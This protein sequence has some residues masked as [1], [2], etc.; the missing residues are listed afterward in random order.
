MKIIYLTWGETP[1]SHGVF[2]SQVIGQ[3]AQTKQLLPDAEFRLVSG[4]PVVH[5]G[6]VR[7]KLRYLDELK[8][9]RANLGTIPFEWIPIYVTQNLY[10]SSRRTFEWMCFGARGKL[11]RTVVEFKPDIVHCRSYHAAWAALQVRQAGAHSFKIV[12][13]ARGLFPEEVALKR[14]YAPGDADFQHL[15]QIEARLLKECDVTIAVSDTMGEHYQALGARNVEVVYLSADFEKLKVP[16]KPEQATERPLEFC[17]VGALA[18]HTWHKISSLSGLAARLKKAFP[19]SKLT[20]VTTSDHDAIRRDFKR[21]N[22]G[23][24]T[25]TSARSA[26]DLARHLIRADFGLMSYFQPVSPQEVKLANMVMAVKVAEYLCAGLPVILNK[27]CGGAVAV[28][29][30][31]D[32][33]TV[34]DPANLE[35]LDIENIRRLATETGVKSRVGATARKL[36]DY[37]VH[38]RQ[39]LEIYRRLM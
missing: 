10:N 4:V 19:D 36:F 2:G 6:L 29:K 17:Y 12:F 3:F 25:V 13:D 16:Y 34:Y 9:I 38:A 7:E 23:Q 39:Y 30:K 1:R 21:W 28:V 24:I 18:E 15:K 26:D 20:I 35:S 14:R 22:P 33:G 8:K 32:M 31:H 11:M 27:Y 5:S 37:S